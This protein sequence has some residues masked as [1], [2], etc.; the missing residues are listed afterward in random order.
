MTPRSLDKD[1][2]GIGLLLDLPFAEGTGTLGTA[3]VARPHHP[4]ALTH[5]PAWTALAS[6]QYVLTLDGSN[7]YL[8]CPG[9]SCADLN[10]I[11]GDFTLAGWVYVEDMASAMIWM[12]RYELDVSGWECFF[13][14]YYLTL[15][16]ST[17]GADPSISCYG[18]TYHPDVWMLVGISRSGVYPRFFRDG[19][20]ME[21]S[22]ETGGI[23]NPT[24]SAQDLVIGVN[25]T[26]AWAFLNGKVGPTRIWNRALAPSEHRELWDRE[27]WIFNV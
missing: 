10:F 15:R 5:S 16:I 24:T 26:K 7:D 13:F 25:H 9:A 17:G 1:S 18:Q 2:L 23:P 3:D 14:N 12:G 19:R 4:V 6:R 20:E 21:A 27:R 22:Y 11:A 8:S